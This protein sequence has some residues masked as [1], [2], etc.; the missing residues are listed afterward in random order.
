MKR[1]SSYSNGSKVRFD[2][3]VIVV[4]FSASIADSVVAFDAKLVCSTFV[5]FTGFRAILLVDVLVSE[6]GAR[7]R[8]K[9]DPAVLLDPGFAR[10]LFI[11]PFGIFLMLVSQF[12]RLHAHSPDVIPRLSRRTRYSWLSVHY[13]RRSLCCQEVQTNLRLGRYVY[14][15]GFMFL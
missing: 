12:P 13:R 15:R 1:T 11:R 6:C 7:R 10:R 14:T 8:P 2:E 9:S 5:P 3:A 4:V